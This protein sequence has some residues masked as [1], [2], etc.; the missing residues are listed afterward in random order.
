M[1]LDITDITHLAY[2]GLLSDIISTQQEIAKVGLY[3]EMRRSTKEQEKQY[4][5]LKSRL[6]EQKQ[7]LEGI[8]EF[9]KENNLNLYF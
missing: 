2:L 5:E 6:S 4:T 7:T 8:K 3:I 1:K 9:A